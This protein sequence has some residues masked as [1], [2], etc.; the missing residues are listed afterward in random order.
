MP[1]EVLVDAGPLIALFDRDDNFHQKMVDFLRS[2]DYRFVTTVAVLTEVSYM[3]NFSVDAQVNFFEWVMLKGVILEEITQKDIAR[4]VGLT[5]KYRDLPMDFA[6]ATLVVAAEKTGIRSIV[7]LDSDFDIYR[8]S[9]KV[10]I[11]NVFSD[12]SPKAGGVGR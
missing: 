10:M 2:R 1:E 12:P 4:V 5:K 9:G 11:M 8:L 3:L 6:D 7:S